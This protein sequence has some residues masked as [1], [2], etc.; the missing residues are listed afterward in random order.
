MELVRRT[1][2]RVNSFNFFLILFE[3]D[4]LGV[5]C[6]TFRGQCQTSKMEHFVKIVNGFYLLTIFAKLCIL[7]IWQ[8]S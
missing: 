4:S 6:K 1:N 8:V 3:I 2:W 7:D 5:P